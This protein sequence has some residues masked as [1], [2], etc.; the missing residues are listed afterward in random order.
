M[1]IQMKLALPGEL[2]KP[3][4][5][6]SWGRIEESSGRAWVDDIISIPSPN[7]VVVTFLDCAGR[8]AMVPP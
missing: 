7:S 1:N 5:G 4:S 2:N 8:V 6:R 3:V